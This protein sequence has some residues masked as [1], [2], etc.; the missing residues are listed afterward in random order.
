MNQRI[1]K[2]FLDTEDGQIFYRI[3]GEGEPL[4]LLHMSPRSSDEFKELMAI[5]APK[6]RVIAMDLM[7]LGDSDKPPREYSISDYAKTV[8]LLL[9]ELGIKK[10]SIL[11]SL[12][13]GYIAGEVA[14]SYRERLNKLILCNVHGFDAEEAEKIAERYRQ[15][16]TMKEDGSHLMERWLTRINYLG[17]ELNHRCIIDDLK[18]FSGPI[19][20]GLAI[21]KYCISARERFK[22]IQCPTLVCTGTRGLEALEKYGLAKPKNQGWLSEAIPHSQVVKIEGGTICM[23]NQMSQEISTVVIDF[24]DN[25]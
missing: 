10:C 1:K 9:D 7:G 6:Y 19:Y 3:G 14:V 22:L 13:G 4:V 11:G 18:A 5:L 25:N 15:G 24:L 17:G 12:T 2:A 8:I 20:T 23:I 21:S 16:F